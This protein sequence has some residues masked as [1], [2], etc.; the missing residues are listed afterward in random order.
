MCRVIEGPH[1]LLT[2]GLGTL[3]IETG[4]TGR[5]IPGQS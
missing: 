2:L 3:R 5:F 1:L 4:L